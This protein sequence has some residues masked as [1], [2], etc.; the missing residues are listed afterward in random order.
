VLRNTGRM[1]EARRIEAQRIEAQKIEPTP[2]RNMLV[3][4]G[5]PMRM[6]HGN[7]IAMS[8]TLNRES[9]PELTGNNRTPT[10]NGARTI[11]T[12]TEMSADKILVKL[13]K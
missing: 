13:R 5:I 12:N 1:T 8:T 7:V 6:P 4:N 3:T 11:R 9:F 2:I 10:G